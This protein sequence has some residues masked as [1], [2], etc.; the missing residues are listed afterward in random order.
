MRTIK[1]TPAA[2]MQA[3]KHESLP[4]SDEERT[5]EMSLFRDVRIDAITYRNLGRLQRPRQMD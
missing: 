4:I 2:N 3:A 1:G 5:G